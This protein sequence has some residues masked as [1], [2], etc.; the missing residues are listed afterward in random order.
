MNPNQHN[1]LRFHCRLAAETVH[2]R[3][4]YAGQGLQYRTDRLI[5]AMS[6]LRRDTAGQFG[7]LQQPRSAAI[8]RRIKSS[9]VSVPSKRSTA[10]V[11][12]RW[13]SGRNGRDTR[14]T[15]SGD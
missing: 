4:A 7:T 13:A 3:F 6:E 10:L 9:F 14:I 15:S 8:I 1:A 11:I 12:W 5:Q 2:P